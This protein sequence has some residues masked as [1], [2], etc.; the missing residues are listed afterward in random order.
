MTCTGMPEGS[1]MADKLTVDAD[2]ATTAARVARA[3]YAGDS[4]E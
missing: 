4:K 2:A 3:A 1:G